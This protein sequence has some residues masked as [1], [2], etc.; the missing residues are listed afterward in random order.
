MVL[1]ITVLV[2]STILLRSQPPLDPSTVVIGLMDQEVSAAEN[3]D[4][5]LVDQSLSAMLLSRTMPANQVMTTY[6]EWT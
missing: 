1:A 4:L 2:L 3:H 5:A 6:L